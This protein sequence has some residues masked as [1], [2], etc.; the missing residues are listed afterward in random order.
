MTCY[1]GRIWRGY[2]LRD[3]HNRNAGV[4][5]ELDY[6]SHLIAG[7]ERYRQKD[8]VNGVL[9]NQRW[10]LREFVDRLIGKRGSNGRNQISGKPDHMALDM[11]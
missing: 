5:T 2:D 4:L 11:R 1:T 3:G 9:P 6:Q 7:V 8:L 10:D